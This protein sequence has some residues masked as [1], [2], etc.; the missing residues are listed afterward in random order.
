VPGT[1]LDPHVWPELVLGERQGT[2][3]YPAIVR[4]ERGGR[5]HKH[6][7]AEQPCRGLRSSVSLGARPWVLA[8]SQRRSS[9]TLL[10]PP[11]LRTLPGGPFPQLGSPSQGA[12]LA[13]GL[14]P[15]ASS[16][17]C[18][19]AEHHLYV[20]EYGDSPVTPPATA[21]PRISQQQDGES[22]WPHDDGME[23]DGWHQQAEQRHDPNLDGQQPRA[24]MTPKYST[25]ELS[26]CSASLRCGVWGCVGASRVRLLV[27]ERWSCSRSSQVFDFSSMC[28]SL[29]VKWKGLSAS[30][31][32]VALP[33][34][35]THQ[36]GA[37][38][39]QL[40]NCRLPL[41]GKH[42]FQMDFG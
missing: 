5:R 6:K 17:G 23:Q 41:D 29:N 7:A 22:R 1:E 30:V 4:G 39:H 15:A 27:Q 16:S 34:M 11:W 14:L 33:V 2:N 32:M 42:I 36:A 13:Q 35:E 18:R 26:A 10:P 21:K 24:Q 12:L 9:L 19:R 31:F 28:F 8:K 20:H 25:E 37:A 3:E 38:K 40:C